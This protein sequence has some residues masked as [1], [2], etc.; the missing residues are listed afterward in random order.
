MHRQCK[1]QGGSRGDHRGCA[2]LQAT[3]SQALQHGCP[4]QDQL[5]VEMAAG[6]AFVHLQ[7][8][9][10]AFRPT[11]KFDK[12]SAEPLDYDSSEKRRVPAWTDRILFRGSQPR[13]APGAVSPHT[14]LGLP[15]GRPAP[16]SCAGPLRPEQS[17]AD[18]KQDTQAVS[19]QPEAMLQG[20][21]DA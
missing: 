18:G 16:T 17:L 20:R 7:E 6:R 2:P 10:I 11:Y 1:L 12:H 4:A 8:A 13:P 15:D 21:C 3:I 14:C 9:P 5:R 19:G